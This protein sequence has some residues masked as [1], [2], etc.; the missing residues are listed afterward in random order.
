MK[1]EDIRAIARERGIKPGKMNKSTL[2]RTI[3]TREGN[4]A[5]YKTKTDCIQD[6]CCW[7]QDCLGKKSSK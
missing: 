3:Q 1:M 4:I 5:C 7:R 2:I 6:D